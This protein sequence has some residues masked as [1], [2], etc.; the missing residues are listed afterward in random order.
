M[1][2]PFLRTARGSFSAG[3]RTGILSRSKDDT[4]LECDFGIRDMPVGID[5]ISLRTVFGNP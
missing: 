5:D 1:H 2:K 3:G 4:V